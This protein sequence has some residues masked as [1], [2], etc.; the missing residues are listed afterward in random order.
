M[1][2]G[3]SVL[4]VA[5][6]SPVSFAQSGLRAPTPEE[7]I[8]IQTPGSPEISPDGKYVV[9]SVREADWQQNEYVTHLWLADVATGRVFQ[10]TQGSKSCDGAGWSPDG[11]WVAFITEREGGANPEPP[12]PEEK[13]KE[14]QK[15]DEEDKT[16]PQGKP[17]GQQIWLISPTG[18][19]AWQL[20][21]H[22]KDVGGFSVVQGRP[23]YRLYR[24]AARKQGRQ[25]PQREVQRI[26]FV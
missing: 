6:F 8:S 24:R 21:K 4:V 7:S 23:V 5:C 3:V 26:R 19:E 10:L 25:G 2:F 12:K 11:R 15:D 1:E 14:E 22:E 17:A 18:G 20:T 9:Y 13:K 16:A